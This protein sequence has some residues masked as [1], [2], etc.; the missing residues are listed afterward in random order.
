M[1]NYG[2]YS[3]LV[4][5]RQHC[6]IITTATNNGHGSGAT[7]DFTFVESGNT[8]KRHR[9]NVNNVKTFTKKGRNTGI[10]AYGFF[11]IP[12]ALK[13]NPLNTEISETRLSDLVGHG[14]KILENQEGFT[15]K[16]TGNNNFK[17]TAKSYSINDINIG[18][19][20]PDLL[21]SLYPSKMETEIY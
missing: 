8:K 17:D 3:E 15:G 18:Q 2:L 16:V 11:E 6:P 12:S 9:S 19:V 4:G 5:Q 13:Y 7:F 20:D 14:N 10:D 1:T 21:H